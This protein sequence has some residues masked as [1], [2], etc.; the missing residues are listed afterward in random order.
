MRTHRRVIRRGLLVAGA[1]LLSGPAA[2][3]ASVLPASASISPPIPLP[4][5]PGVCTPADV[6][7]AELVKTDAGPVIE[8]TGV[9][10]QP[11]ASVRL[12]P[13]DIDFIR[14]PDYFP[15]IVSSCGSG[16]VVKTPFTATF[17]VPTFPVGRLGISIHDI[18]IDLFPPS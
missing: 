18:L 10:F 15:Y 6:L 13:E 16:R 14:Q 4:P 2:L 1:L 9:K 11:D 8:V 12:D 17:R 3:A 5:P 7:T